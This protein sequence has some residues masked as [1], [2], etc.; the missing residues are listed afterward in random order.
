M[1]C[2]FTWDAWRAPVPDCGNRDPY[3]LFNTVRKLHR[4]CTS[5]LSVGGGYGIIETL[6]VWFFFLAFI[7]M[8]FAKC[9]N[10]GYVMEIWVYICCL[11]QIKIYK[12]GENREN[13]ESVSL[14]LANHLMLR[15]MLC[16]VLLWSLSD[17]IEALRDS[18]NCLRSQ[19]CS[20]RN[21]MIL[22]DLTPFQSS[23]SKTLLFYVSSE[24]S[25]MFGLDCIS[26]CLAYRCEQ[27]R[28]PTPFTELTVQV[29]TATGILGQQ[30][31]ETQ[32]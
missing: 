14:T 13:N 7:G 12:H 15:F 20:G 23:F 19:L 1:K 29:E 25:Q 22:Q 31:G 3:I 28:H 21:R 8:I 26:I 32:C 10:T 18:L 16:S 24:V 17:K 5:F 6:S 2:F 30:V 27:G 11:F 4:K 9:G